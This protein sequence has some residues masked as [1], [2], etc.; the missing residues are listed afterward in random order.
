MNCRS[1]N[2]DTFIARKIVGGWEVVVY[3]NDKFERGDACN[4]FRRLVHDHPDAAAE[5]GMKHNAW[6]SGCGGSD[7]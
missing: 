1:E 4:N 5:C 7:A 2:H 6:P 3:S